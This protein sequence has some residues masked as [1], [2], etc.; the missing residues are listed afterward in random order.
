MKEIRFNQDKN[1]KLK[2]TRGIGFD[3]VAKIIKK[4]EIQAVIDNPN[5]KKY[6]NQKLFLIKIENSVIV[7]PFVEEKDYIFLKTV[8]PSQKYTKK[9]LAKKLKVKK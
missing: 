9:Y 7:V 8:Y 1:T 4:N 6:Q 2:L 3:E 5:K